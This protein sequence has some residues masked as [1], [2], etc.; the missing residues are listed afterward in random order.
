MMP[1]LTAFLPKGDQSLRSL[2]IW[3]ARPPLGAFEVAFDQN[4]GKKMKTINGEVFMPQ[5]LRRVQRIETTDKRF[6]GWFWEKYVLDEN[7]VE[8]EEEELSEYKGMEGMFRPETCG[9]PAGVIE[10]TQSVVDAVERER[11]T[12]SHKTHTAEEMDASFKGNS[13]RPAIVAKVATTKKGA[14]MLEIE[15]PTRDP[16]EDSWDEGLLPSAIRYDEAE[17]EEPPTKSNR[18][19]GRSSN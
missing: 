17:A 10:A 5:F 15:A 7:E 3:A 1:T 4:T 16:D 8:Y 12:M 9:R 2:L 6:L 18:S 14:P 13:S 11:E 19:F